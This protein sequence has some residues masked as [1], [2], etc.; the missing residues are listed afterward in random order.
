[1]SITTVEGCM[2]CS[3]VSAALVFI[4]RQNIVH[5]DIRAQNF[6]VG[7]T[8]EEIKLTKFRLG[9]DVYMDQQYIAVSS[10]TDNSANEKV[11][12]AAPESIIDLT[13]THASDVWSTAITMVEIFSLG[14]VP[15][16][17]MRPV[18]P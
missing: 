18:I 7:R 15:H 2:I 14:K 17:A 11:R 5:R 6:M 1:M 9:R 10:T 16:G 8:L 12:W 3:S 13:Y 4:G